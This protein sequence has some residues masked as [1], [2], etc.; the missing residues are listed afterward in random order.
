MARS[1]AKLSGVMSIPVELIDAR[2]VQKDLTI[3]F[4]PMGEEPQEIEAFFM[5]GD[6]INV[7]RQYGLAL[8]TRQG[9]EFEDCTSL[10]FDGVWPR[11][12]EPREYQIDYIDDCVDATQNFY[13]FLA[14][15]H[16]GFGK[17]ISALI[18]AARVGRTT[19]I[20]VDQENLKLQWIEALTGLFGFAEADIGTI[21]GKVC[22]Y[23]GKTVVIAMVQTLT[24][25]TYKQEVYD[26]FGMVIVDEVHIIGAP[27]FSRI[28]MLLTAAYRFGVSATPKRRDGLQKLLDYNLGRVRVAADKEHDESAVYFAFH[29]TIY[30]WYAN[31]SPKTGRFISEVAEDGSRNFL[32][33]ESMVWLHETGR[34]VLILSDRIEHLKHLMSLAYY[35]GIPEEDMG[36]Y[37]GYDPIY[38]IGKDPKPKKRPEGYQRGTEYTPIH[39]SL[40]TKRISKKRLA[41]VKEN[42]RMMFATYGMFAK[43]VDVPRLAAGG[44]GTPRTA[45]EQ[46]HGRILREQDGKKKP[47]W[48]TL[49]DWNSPR[50]LF[51]F[52]NRAREYVKSNARLFEWKET[53][54]IEEWHAG[55]LVGAVA[56]RIQELKE[57]RI[58][59][60]KDGLNT[61]AMSNT[62]SEKR[63]T[64]DNSIVEKIQSLRSSQTGSG[65]KASSAKS[66][67][68]TANTPSR[69]KA[70]PSRKPPKR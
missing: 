30:S 57:Y 16:T 26:Y 55:D 47:I 36:L 58:E 21:Q 41:D 11:I 2:R 32:L 33:M 49:C 40:M 8:C 62:V 51:S 25:K 59:T 6:C 14:R 34:D 43:G 20:I 39:L 42:A 60:S 66:S 12:P 17:T 10:G 45:A 9:I 65:R 61:L 27:T 67:T 35:M 37:A 44:D 7:P 68:E 19:L 5:D 53:G 63:K 64:R 46:V 56:R 54:G 22:D 3:T 29:D 70:S 13:D 38:G 18:T 15:A 50:A 4:A 52:M 28:L 24:Q 69:S 48:F 23:K 1:I 31:I